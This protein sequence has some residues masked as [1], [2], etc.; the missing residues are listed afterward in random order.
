MDGRNMTEVFENAYVTAPFSQAETSVFYRIRV[1]G[2]RKRIERYV[3]SNENALVCPLENAVKT[4]V[5]TQIFLCVFKIMKTE[6]LFQSALVTALS[7]TGQSKTLLV[8]QFKNLKNIVFHTRPY[9]KCGWLN[10]KQ[11]F[12]QGVSP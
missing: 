3:F 2:R 6:E 9:N 8:W 11:V 10:S 7:N 1:D 5:W 12:F 4:L